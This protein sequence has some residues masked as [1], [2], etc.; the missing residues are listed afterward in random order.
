MLKGIRHRT[1][2]IEAVNSSSYPVTR[3]SYLSRSA[4]GASRQEGAALAVGLVFLLVLTIFGISSLS[5]TLLEEKMSANVQ[6]QN[7]AFQSAELGATR[8]FIEIVQ[9]IGDTAN[10][11]V[12]DVC[13]TTSGNAEDDNLTTPQCTVTDFGE[14]KSGSRGGGAFSGND[15]TPSDLSDPS[16]YLNRGAAQPYGSSHFHYR[17]N[18]E[19]VNLA[20]AK[21]IVNLG[22]SIA[23]P[24]SD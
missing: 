4:F 19:A 24:G 2:N 16:N 7:R 23:R 12:K 17:I 6:E 11:G 10:L 18:S 21:A 22:V 3:T 1:P 20:K 5:T 13:D 8:K 15:L 9:T 14:T